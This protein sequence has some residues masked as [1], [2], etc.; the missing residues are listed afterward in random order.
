MFPNM[1]AE[2]DMAYKI[3]NEEPILVIMGNPPYNS[4]SEEINCKEWIINLLKDYKQNLNEKKINLDDDYI[5]FLRFAH[6]KMDKSKQGII[7]VIVNNSFINGVTHREMRNQLMKTF[8]E[9]YIFDLHG[10]MNKGEKCL[11][12]SQDFNIFNIKDVGVCI[13]LLVKTGIKNNK[14]KEYIFRR[15]LESKIIKKNI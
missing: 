12:G 3:K 5:K 4:K 13:A 6:W 11:D 10:N 8:D 15:F 14:N 7:G 9:I 2:A 1:K